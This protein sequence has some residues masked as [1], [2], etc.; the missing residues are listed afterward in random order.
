MNTATNSGT[1]TSLSIIT[2]S[3]FL[4]VTDVDLLIGSTVVA[5]A[6]LN[7]ATHYQ[8]YDQLGQSSTFKNSRIEM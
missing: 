6:N 1:T 2:D 5:K 4:F 7:T 8:S 3:G